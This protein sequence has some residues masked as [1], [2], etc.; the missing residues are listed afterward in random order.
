MDVIAGA[1]LGG[2]DSYPH[3]TFEARS[4]EEFRSNG[5]GQCVYFIYTHVCFSFPPPLMC[6]ILCQCF[7]LLSK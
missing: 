7:S 2:S 4:A 3:V 1:D 5:Y 6:I